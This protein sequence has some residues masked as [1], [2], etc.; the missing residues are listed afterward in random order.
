M[1]LVAS[2]SSEED[3]PSSY[4]GRRASRTWLFSACVR[5]KDG[6]TF[7]NVLDERKKQVDTS[8]AFATVIS[9]ACTNTACIQ[10]QNLNFEGF[11]HAS[12]LFRLVSL[13]R[14]LPEQQVFI[15]KERLQAA[16]Q[17]FQNKFSRLGCEICL[18]VG[19]QGHCL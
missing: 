8:L 5:L 7:S 2:A 11:G 16:L 17:P 10:S 14:R 1:S 6:K 18:Y 19:A 15:R 4:D 9:W 13:R 3:D 12:S